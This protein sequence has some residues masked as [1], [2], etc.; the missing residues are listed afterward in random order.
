[1]YHFQK[2]DANYNIDRVNGRTG[3]SY[4]CVMTEDLLRFITVYRCQSLASP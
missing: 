3:E 1:M 2:I 4:N